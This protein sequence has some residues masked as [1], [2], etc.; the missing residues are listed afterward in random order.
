MLDT[1]AG[2][3]RSA[4]PFYR[5]NDFPKLKFLFPHQT[6]WGVHSRKKFRNE[7]KMVAKNIDGLKLTNPLSKVFRK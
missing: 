1:L 6:A 4:H 5:S 7:N 3:A 2:A